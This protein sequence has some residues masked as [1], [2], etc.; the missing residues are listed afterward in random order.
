MISFE[1]LDRESLAGL[2]K[3]LAPLG[4]EEFIIG[5]LNSFLEIAEEGAEVGVTAAGGVILVRIFEGRDYSFVYPIEVGEESELDKALTA[6]ADY[7][8]REMI[9]FYLT[10]VPRCELDRLRRLFSHLDARAY[11]D[12]DVFGTVFI[13][14]FLDT[15]LVFQVHCTCAR[16]NE[17]L[18]G[19]KYHFAAGL[20][21]TG[22]DRF[23]GYAVAIADDD[24]FLPL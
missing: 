23:A 12:D 3:K 20:L 11:D 4:D 9:P 8:V 17:A 2:S 16:S 21:D 19:G 1:I 10:D 15:S 5:V 18:G 22:L 24:D 14:K 6:L 13:S 7:A